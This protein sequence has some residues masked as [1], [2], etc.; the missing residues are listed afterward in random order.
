M[1]SLNQIGSTRDRRVLLSANEI[2]KSLCAGLRGRTGAVL[3][4]V[5]RWSVPA[6]AII[7]NKYH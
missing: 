3:Y 5:R 4:E 1:S 7:K 2:D 6:E